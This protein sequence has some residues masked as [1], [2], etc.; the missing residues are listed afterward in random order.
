MNHRISKKRQNLQLVRHSLSLSLILVFVS[1]EMSFETH[2]AAAVIQPDGKI[3][4]IGNTCTDRS[5][6]F[7]LV[8]YLSDTVTPILD[9]INDA[10]FFVHQHFLD[11]LNREPDTDGLAFWTNEIT[12]CGADA[13]CIDVKRINVSAAFFLS[14]EFQNTGYLVER[15]KQVFCVAEKLSPYIQAQ[16]HT[17]IL[18][19]RSRQQ[20]S[21][22]SFRIL[23]TR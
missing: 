8:R 22:P 12:S 14:I 5:C 10:Q 23:R 17:S 16:V 20:G 21:G 11:F 19:I 6:D 2:A 4:A 15:M 18:Q 13:Q 9:P 3:V 7:A 1:V